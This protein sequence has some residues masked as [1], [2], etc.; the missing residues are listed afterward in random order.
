MG[1]SRWE[2][3]PPKTIRININCILI[4]LQQSSLR[5]SPLLHNDRRVLD[6][7]QFA[8]DWSATDD[9]LHTFAAVIDKM[10]VW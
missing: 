2:D 3:R 4:S 5:Q 10:A 7:L 6:R 1:A 9:G 8:P